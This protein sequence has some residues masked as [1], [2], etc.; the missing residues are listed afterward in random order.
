MFSGRGGN[1]TNGAKERIRTIGVASP[2][3]DNTFTISGGK[4]HLNAA[5][6]V[7][8]ECQVAADSEEFSTSTGSVDANQVDGEALRITQI[9]SER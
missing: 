8:W 5:D 1:G 7:R 6:G 4:K 3:F 9:F 2:D